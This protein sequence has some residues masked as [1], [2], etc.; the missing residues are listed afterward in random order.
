MQTPRLALPTG[1]RLENYELSR[2]LGKGG[3][4]ITY[5]GI[6][7]NLGRKVAVKELMPDTIVTREGLLVRPQS[8]SLAPNWAW[9]KDRFLEEACML[10]SFQ[11]RN[12]VNVHQI[13]EANGTVYMVMDYIEGDSY[14]TR[15]R[16]I[17][18]ETD[19]Q[20]LRSILEPLLDGL[21]EVHANG[22]LHRD[23]KPDNIILRR[24]VEPIL[25]DFGSARKLLEG[26]AAMTSI[27]THGYSPI[28]Q[29]QI[30]GKQGPWTDIYALGAVAVRAITGL[31]PPVSADRVSEDEFEWLSYRDLPRFSP[32]FLR[33]IDWAL[34]VKPKER[35][36][37]I[38]E[39]RS[40]FGWHSKPKT[41][42][43][44]TAP[45]SRSTQPA[46]ATLSTTPL[47]VVQPPA[48][49]APA[50]RTPTH[51]SLQLAS[52]LQPFATRVH[53][54]VRRRPL[55]AALAAAAALFIGIWIVS[56]PSHPTPAAP[57]S[58]G[59]KKPNAV[60]ATPVKAQ[61]TNSLGMPFVRLPGTKILLCVWDTRRQDY[62]TFAQETHRAWSKPSFQQEPDHPAVNVSWDDAKAFCD[63]LGRKENR[64]YRLPTDAEWSLAAGLPPEIG[65]TPMEKDG[66][67]KDAYPWGGSWPPTTGA[68]N[69][70][71]SL[72]VDDYENT[73]PVGA[74]G[75]NANGLC[76]MGGNVWQWCEDWYDSHNKNRV[77]RGGAWNSCVRE[78]TRSSFRYYANPTTGYDYVGFRCVI[79]PRKT[80]EP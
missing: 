9:A 59:S 75:F 65:S 28:E 63:W 72:R 69:Y 48:H 22:L 57:G 76:D 13:I 45:V 40:S 36:N 58:P 68:G 53:A 8:A 30:K 12:I 31:K 35:P 54:W 11:H 38:A 1:C 66:Q 43:N 55:A 5:L 80:A 17:G 34:R 32:R 50:P 61:Y 46:P 56:G 4:G 37:N 15:L 41:L 47:T 79:E 18:K 6:D 67:D 33:A 71:S 2:V 77:L 42:V 78:I 44:R 14:D 70:A 23:I 64:A 39:W 20:S 24:D 25:L 19:E 27:V 60:A 52:R 7:R 74:F 26:T 3:F 21:E 51:P 62:E 16:R 49:P 10:A 29:Y 73:S